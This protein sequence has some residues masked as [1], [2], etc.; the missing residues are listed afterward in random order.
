[1]SIFDLTQVPS[2]LSMQLIGNTGLFLSP[3][4]ASAQTLDRGGLKWQATYNYSNISA[5][6]RATLMGLLARLR[7]QAHR[8]RVPVYDNPKRGAYGGTPL[9]NGGSQTGSVV[10]IDGCSNNITNWIRA[11]DYFSIVVNGEHELKMCTQ[12]NSSNGSGQIATLEFEPRLR[13]SPL[14]NAVIFV[15]DGAI[16][17][18]EGIFVLSSANVGWNSRPFQTASELSQI[19]L[20]LTEDVFATQ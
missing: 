3:L 8:L 17:K 14:N 20:S 16:D 12:D 7:A 11:G 1:M 4:I 18:P 2:T 5:D 19:I 13:A 6:R 9:V 10:A 15:E